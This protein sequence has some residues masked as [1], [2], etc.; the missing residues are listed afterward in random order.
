MNKGSVSRSL[1][2][3]LSFF[4]SHTLCLSLPPF[5]SLSLSLSVYPSLSILLSLTPSLFFP[6]SLPFSGGG[7]HRVHRSGLQVHDR[8]P[9]VVREPV[10]RRRH[11]EPDVGLMLE[12]RGC[13]GFRERREHPREEGSGSSLGVRTQGGTLHPK[14]RVPSHAAQRETSA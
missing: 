13:I 10:H 1:S 2:L 8:M 14:M 6:L 11:H 3:S 4:L 5:R 9:V 12:F 7:M